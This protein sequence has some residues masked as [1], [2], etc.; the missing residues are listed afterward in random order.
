M[1]GRVSLNQELW[2][3]WLYV[4]DGSP[5]PASTL[6]LLYVW[7]MSS[8]K[9]ISTKCSRNLYRSKTLDLYSS[10]SPEADMKSLF[11]S[12]LS[13]PSHKS[14]S[15]SLWDLMGKLGKVMRREELKIYSHWAPYARIL[16]DS[17]FVIEGPVWF[18]ANTKLNCRQMIADGVRECILANTVSIVALH[19]DCLP[20]FDIGQ[21]PN[22]G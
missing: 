11:E 13:G 22:L 1:L 17:G 20:A 7:V 19:L 2:C 8:T 21:F 4:L 15:V 9:Q 16:R 3:W 14:P 10:N 6:L 18:L 5:E 12:I